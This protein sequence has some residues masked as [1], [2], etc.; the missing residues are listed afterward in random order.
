MKR[1]AIQRHTP[2]GRGSS[3]LGARKEPRRTRHALPL[4]PREGGYRVTLGEAEGE[5]FAKGPQAALCERT[6]CAACFA[7]RLWRNGFPRTRALPWS[8]LITGEA[9]LV[10]IAH[11]EPYRSTTCD[12]HDEDTYPLCRKHHTD[13]WDCCRHRQR[14]NVTDMRSFYALLPFDWRAVIAEMRRRTK[15]LAP[16]L[17]TESEPTR[18][19]VARRP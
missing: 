6:E 11:H 10:S 8:L 1:T 3:K 19:G 18:V 2:L 16:I 12:S 14:S 13:G 7:V 9:E 17:G 4:P 5:A 15:S